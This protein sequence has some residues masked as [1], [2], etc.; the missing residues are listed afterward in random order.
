MNTTQPPPLTDRELLLI[1]L[2]VQNKLATDVD[3]LTQRAVRI[4]TRLSKLLVHSGLGH[5]GREPYRTI[6][7]IIV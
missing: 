1:L 5:D 6:E 3:L 2:D 4:E 7:T